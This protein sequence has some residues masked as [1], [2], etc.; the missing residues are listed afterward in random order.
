MNNMI[1]VHICKIRLQFIFWLLISFSANGQESIIETKSF[2]SPSVNLSLKYTVILPLSYYQTSVKYPV[3][4]LLH[5][6]TGNYSSWLSY[7]KLPANLA[8]MHN[9]IIVLPDGGN[10]WY[11]NWTGQTDGK[12]HR[13]E[14]MIVKDLVPE[15]DKTFRTLGA[16][17]GRAIGGLSM[18]GYGAIAVGLKNSDLFGFVFSSAG[19]INFCKNIKAEMARDTVDWNSPQLWSDDKKIVD[20]PGFANANERTPKGLVF[21]KAAH[22][23]TYDPYLLFPSVET[24]K[25]PYI[26][27]DCGNNDDFY[28][29][30]LEFTQ[31]LKTRTKNFSLV[32]LSGSHDVPYWEQSV[33]HTFLVMRQQN[34]LKNP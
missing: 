6:H 23:D 27:I 28:S 3:V 19:A 8:T 18:G 32:I 15:V 21:A 5:G 13:W 26:H 7:A 30:A 1:M 16:R 12:P 17:S 9:C 2:Y 33:V 4:Y 34:F 14:D 22:A 20:V 11:V 10:S 31:L 29:S 24:T 25:L